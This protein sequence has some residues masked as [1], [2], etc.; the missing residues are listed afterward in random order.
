MTANE[1]TNHVCLAGSSETP[2]TEDTNMKDAVKHFNAT[3]AHVAATSQQLV[4]SIPE[5]FGVATP[6]APTVAIPNTPAT[7]TSAEQQELDIKV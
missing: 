7:D 6:E 1:P 4:V 2:K 3:K 5:D